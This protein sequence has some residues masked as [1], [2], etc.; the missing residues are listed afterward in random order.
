MITDP[1]PRK[2]SHREEFARSDQLAA[3]LVPTNDRLKAIA[4]RIEAAMKTE[5]RGDIKNTCA[6]FL[7]V[8]SSFYKVREPGISVL[9]ARPLR[10]REGGWRTEIFGDYAPDRM[11]MRVWMRTA[12]QKRVTSFGTFLSTLCHEFCHHLDMQRFGFTQSPHTR[13]FYAR[14]AI[15]YHHTRGTPMRPLVWRRMPRGRWMIDWMAMK[16]GNGNRS[17]PR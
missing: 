10:V 12:V 1:V 5:A 15:L 8:A 3:L 11:F 16:A 14:A 7:T 17:A 4:E 6:A 2:A 13:G 9:A